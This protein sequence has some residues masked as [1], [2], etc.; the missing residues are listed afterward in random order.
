MAT[1]LLLLMTAGNSMAADNMKNVEHYPDHFV[2]GISDLDRGMT[3]VEE[4]T[5][6]RPVFGGAHPHIGTHNALIA[7]G[8]HSY[9]EIIAPNPDADLSMLDPDLKAQFM[10]PLQGMDTLTP[11]LW[12]I[13][14]SDL[15][16][17]RRLLQAEGVHL[18]GPQPG[19]R[20]KPD[21]H[22]LEW[23]AAFVTGPSARGL[24]FF[25]QWKDPADSPPNDSPKGCVLN[26]FSLT[27]P[28]SAVLKKILDTLSLTAVVSAADEPSLQIVLD[29]PAG[30]VQI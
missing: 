26:N 5:G 7:L 19:S 4:L 13:G 27:G 11:F 22:S 3:L 30:R 24:P 9:L 29:C 17:T 15:E 6:V 10:D 18:S 21:G 23:I 28:D 2:V 14:S 8:E 25:I 20:K 12:A 16:S 1:T